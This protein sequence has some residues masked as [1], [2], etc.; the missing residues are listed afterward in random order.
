M[1]YR[2]INY[3]NSTKDVVHLAPSEKLVELGELLESGDVT[4]YWT[5]DSS[6]TEIIPVLQ[7]FQAIY[8]EVGKG[9]RN[10]LEVLDELKKRQFD[11]IIFES[12]VF[13]AY[14]ELSVR[15][16]RRKFSK[17]AMMIIRIDN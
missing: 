12:Y 7:I 8:D 13:S 9:M 17:M 2:D 4:K 11:V 5:Q 1:R 15:G 3:T 6:S 14:R 10:N 16:F